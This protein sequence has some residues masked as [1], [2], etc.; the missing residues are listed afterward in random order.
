MCDLPHT[1]FLLC[2]LLLPPP[3]IPHLTCVLIHYSGDVGKTTSTLKADI[4]YFVQFLTVFALIQA[5]LVFIVGVTRGISPVNGAQ[6]SLHP[7]LLTPSNAHQFTLCNIYLQHNINIFLSVTYAELVTNTVPFLPIPSVFVQGFIVIMIGNVPQVRL[8]F[9]SFPLFPPFLHLH[10]SSTPF[11]S[12]LSWPRLS[13][14]VS[15]STLTLLSIPRPLHHRVFL[16]QLPLASSLWLR[17]W[18]STMCSLRNSTSLRPWGPALSS[19]Q[20]RDALLSSAYGR[21]FAVHLI[22]RAQYI[23]QDLLTNCTHYSF[24]SSKSIVTVAL[25]SLILLFSFR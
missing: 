10:L 17:E 6:H 11:P 4:Q 7:H 15:D 24:L 12:L 2:S 16:P 3:L 23:N 22:C 13:T 9:S 1:S 19:A 8:A 5:A 21:H 25:T 18:D 14:H 20:V